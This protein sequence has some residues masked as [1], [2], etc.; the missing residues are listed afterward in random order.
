MGP[1]SALLILVDVSQQFL[2]QKCP[3]D[4]PN[5]LEAVYV[6]FLPCI[7]N[8]YSAMKYG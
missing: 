1:N 6:A 7:I 8:L 4:N 2:Q 3:D 5:P